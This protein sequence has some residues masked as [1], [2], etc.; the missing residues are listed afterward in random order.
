M[1]HL[2]YRF[3]SDL[4]DKLIMGLI[5]GRFACSVL[6]IWLV[7]AC[8]SG[9]PISESGLAVSAEVRAS[10]VKMEDAIQ[11][12]LLEVITKDYNSTRTEMGLVLSPTDTSQIWIRIDAGLQVVDPKRADHIYITTQTKFVRLAR[13]NNFLVTLPFVQ[14]TLFRSFGIPSGAKLTRC[15]DERLIKFFSAID[16]S[17]ESPEW[18][19]VQIATWV[20]TQDISFERV[21]VPPKDGKVR[22]TTHPTIT[23]RE[24]L[25]IFEMLQKVGHEKESFALWTEAMDELDH[26]VGRY[27]SR[28]DGN[29]KHT[30]RP[31]R[32][33]CDLYPLESAADI[34]VSCFDRHQGED[35]L[36]FRSY[37]FETLQK[38]SGP[39][40]HE[41]IKSAAGL[42]SDSGLFE[43]MTAAIASAAA[44]AK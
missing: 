34:L 33:I 6:T 12:G 24:M 5:P 39:V 11:Q 20:L 32:L 22:L 36:A 35:G 10:A 37:A 16:S 26:L 21:R 1:G 9:G 18:K 27:E 28:V 2:G 15:E 8:N 14:R 7:T 30:I 4:A 29:P 43:K 25:D 3:E 13:R 23:S 40:E 38:V 42:E 19:H 41:M 31:F 44:P 17:D